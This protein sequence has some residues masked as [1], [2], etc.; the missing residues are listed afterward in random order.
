M[1]HTKLSL[2]LE[3]LQKTITEA[4][5]AAKAPRRCSKRELAELVKGEK[6]NLFTGQPPNAV[7]LFPVPIKLVKHFSPEWKHQ[8]D[9]ENAKVL[10]LTAHKDPIKLIIEWMLAGGVDSNRN[11]SIPYSQ[12]DVHKLLSLNKLVAFLKIDSLENRTLKRIDSITR[13]QPL[14]FEQMTRLFSVASIPSET[15]NVLQR[16]LSRWVAALSSDEWEKKYSQ[17]STQS[18]QKPALI[19][20]SMLRLAVEERRERQIS[21]ETSKAFRRRA[22][23]TRNETRGNVAPDNMQI[24]GAKTAPTKTKLKNTQKWT[25][26]LSTTKTTTKTGSEQVFQEIQLVPERSGKLQESQ[27]P[28]TSRPLKAQKGQ[29]QL[30]NTS[31]NRR[32]DT[33][34]HVNTVA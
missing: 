1:S 23:L 28:S 16:N 33:T 6:V 26:G 8:L 17:A 7:F 22:T 31:Q 18:D 10:Y 14:S 12:N 3:P 13:S 34:N 21:L 5:K 19:I 29:T 27:L 15:H 4:A 20:L 30:P 32:G 25:T 9:E 2:A 24:A 11:G